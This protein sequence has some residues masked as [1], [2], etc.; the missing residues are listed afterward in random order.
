MR[1]SGFTEERVT[2]A[3]R[4]KLHAR[5]PTPDAPRPTPHAPRQAESGTPVAGCLPAAGCQ[6]SELL[7]LE[8]EVRQ[9]DLTELRELRQLDLTELCELRQLRDE[10]ARPG[11]VVADLALDKHILGEVARRKL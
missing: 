1:K 3:P 2:D 4:P 11:R 6:R 9:L 8:E 7:R 5:R 10:N